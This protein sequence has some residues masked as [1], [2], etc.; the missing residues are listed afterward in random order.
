MSR[1]ISR[2][3]LLQQATGAAAGAVAAACGGGALRAAPTAARAAQDG[4]TAG[5]KITVVGR[6]GTIPVLLDNSQDWM[7]QTG[8]TVEPVVV[9]TDLGRKILQS[10]VT[11]AFLADV[12]LH[13]DNYGADLY[14]RGYY[15]EVPADV[16]GTVGWDD[17]VP[18]YRDRLSGWQGKTYGI[19][20][21]GDNMFLTY[22]RDLMAD[23]AIQE[24]F[25]AA[26]G[27]GMDPATGPKSWQE[28]G[29]YAEFFTGWAWD[30]SGEEGYGLSSMWKRGGGLFWAFCS[31]AAAY[32]KHP[33]A[34]DFYFDVETGDP[35]INSEAF[36][37]AL[38]EWKTEMETY[39]PPGALN[40]EWANGNDQLM[41][42]R[43]AMVNYWA[44]TGKDAQDPENSTVK[45]KLGYHLTPGSTD[46]YNPKAR[47]WETQPEVSHAPF[48]GFG[49]RNFAI[50][51]DT[52]QAEASWEFL[53]H[54]C[55]P[56][57]TLTVSVTPGSGMD[58]VRESQFNVDA[59]V[60]S[61]FQWNPDEA[62]SYLDTI[63]ANL[64]HP[65]L[66]A[67]LRLPGWTQY[68][69]ALETSVSAVLAG[70]S[71]AQGALDQAAAQWKSITGQLGGAE[72]QM[73]YYRDL[74]GV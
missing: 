43:V 50:A 18:F 26:Y 68:Q 65:N 28:H 27:Y 35:L 24:R 70:S 56:E 13:D 19:P 17:I 44:D 62:R 48:L 54:A 22:R 21:D 36:V 23:P 10:A 64:N 20:Y 52:K 2:R 72:K 49:G 61:P 32:A 67:D 46:V 4:G 29:Q 55:S 53:K 57:T 8:I 39:A 63:R 12:Q 66:V 16:K 30:P 45:G 5:A 69:D 7:A 11:G 38:T 73:T 42:G 14:A 34:P 60:N 41:T 71:E 3:Q 33:G 74:L 25:T 31:R 6:E 51:R 58:P 1:G 37:R 9:S 40:F 47:A 15:Q 59:W